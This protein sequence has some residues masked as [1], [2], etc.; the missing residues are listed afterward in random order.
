MVIKSV[1]VLSVGKMYG[2][3]AAAMG[4]LFGIFIALF[5]TV[6]GAGL[7]VYGEN[8]SGLIASMFGVGAVV[9]LPIFYGCMGFIA[10]A[11]GALLYNAFA[12][13]VGGVEIQTE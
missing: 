6:A 3:I 9:I 12:G 13:V 7:G 5:S 10:G 1:G 2:A 4:L 11:V 8:Q